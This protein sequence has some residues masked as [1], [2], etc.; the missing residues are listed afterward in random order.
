MQATTDDRFSDEVA[1]R[2]ENIFG[3]EEP[4]EA[5]DPEGT[6]VR[7]FPLRDL[8][9]IVLAIDWEITDET[10]TGFAEQIGVLQERYRD[11]KI[12]LVFLQLLGSIGEYIRT[13]LGQSHPDAFRILNSLYGEL[14][15]ML[16]SE[17]LTETQKKKVLSQ[18]LAKYKKLKEQLTPRT[19]AVDAGQPAK[20]SASPSIGSENPRTDFGAAIE[21]LKRLFQSEI[22][23]LKDEVQLLRRQ[24]AGRR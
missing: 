10:M 11:D 14:E 5:S 9:T 23:A 13:H 18:E 4:S 2:L 22:R 7:D 8:K 16:M 15:K 1:D 19:P 6:T 24:I 21:E 3:D 17:D 20:A 12:V